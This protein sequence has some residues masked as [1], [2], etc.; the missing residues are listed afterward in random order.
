MLNTLK[1]RLG[2]IPPPLVLAARGGCLKEFIGM[3]LQNDN[4]CKMLPIKMASM[5]IPKI[6][7]EPHTVK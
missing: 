3:S 4:N 1:D 2:K 6:K 7:L 5:K